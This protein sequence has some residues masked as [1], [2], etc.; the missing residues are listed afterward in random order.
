[1]GEVSFPSPDQYPSMYL[2]RQRIGAENG[3]PPAHD[4]PARCGNPNLEH[5]I[6][7]RV[8]EASSTRG[9]YG[10]IPGSGSF[11]LGFWTE[12]RQRFHR[13]PREAAGCHEIPRGM[14]RDPTWDAAG[15]R[16]FP[17]IPWHP[18]WDLA[19][20]RRMLGRPMGSQMGS[21]R[22]SRDPM[23]I[24][25]NKLPWELSMGTHEIP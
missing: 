1:M 20:C 7:A 4:R 9:G 18:R 25:E 8:G 15:C 22:M 10:L 13:I 12:S 5:I 17:C 14:P 16:D 2:Q 19:G 3:D 24:L 11:P 6:V 23:R 21:R